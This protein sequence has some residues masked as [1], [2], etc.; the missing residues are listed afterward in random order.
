MTARLSREEHNRI[1]LERLG[2]KRCVAF[3]RAAR[4]RAGCTAVRLINEHLDRGLT[5]ADVLLR[6][7]EQDAG[8]ALE[9]K[10]VGP[11]HFHIDFGFIGPMLG[12][13]GD[14]DVEFDAGGRVERCLGRML[15]VS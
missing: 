15:W 12:D 11:L 10:R 6:R 5:I 3:L 1:A 9:V 7:D 2:E 14:W 13:G 4:A 8:F